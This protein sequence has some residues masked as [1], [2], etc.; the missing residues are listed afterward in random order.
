M[1]V[2]CRILREVSHIQTT[3]PRFFLDSFGDSL[4][5]SLVPRSLGSYYIPGG[6]ERLPG[7]HSTRHDRD[8]RGGKGRMLRY[9]QRRP[10]GY[11]DYRVDVHMH[12]AEMKAQMW[13]SVLPVKPLVRV[14]LVFFRFPSC[15]RAENVK[16]ADD[17]PEGTSEA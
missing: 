5:R 14:L 3:P 16:N 11:S 15:P 17:Q 10:N 2:P 4:R 7:E 1:P 6:L 9:P 8:V 13:R 12:A